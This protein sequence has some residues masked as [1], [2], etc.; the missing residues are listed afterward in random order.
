MKKKLPIGQSD[1]KRI[2]EDKNYYID[3]TLMIKELL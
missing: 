2:I 3:K 1:F